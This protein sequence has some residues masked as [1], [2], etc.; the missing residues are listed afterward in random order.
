MRSVVGI[1]STLVVLVGCGTSNN[2]TPSDFRTELSVD[3]IMHLVLEPSADLLWSSAGF[4]V[5]LAGEESLAPTTDEG[6]F[7]VESAAGIV[8][9]CGNLLL[10]P[11]RSE[12]REEWIQIS[13][14]MVDAAATARTAALNQDAT[15]L[16]QAG[17][18]L[19]QTCVSC[20]T[21]YWVQEN[22]NN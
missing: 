18:D 16:F 13:N 10:I 8:Q 3:E 5:T 17:A 1:L 20:H 9:E 22:E 7:A 11:A 19:Y 4:V 14:S 21:K 6:W 2:A 15:L 12:N